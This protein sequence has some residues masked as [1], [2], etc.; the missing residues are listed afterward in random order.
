M[1]NTLPLLKNI[2]LVAALSMFA[3]TTLA[4]GTA[5]TYQGQLRSSGSPANGRY[6][7]TF[8]LF[9]AS[10]GGNPIG[11]TVNASGVVVS[12]GIFTVSLDFGA[13]FPGADR[14]LEISVRTNGAVSFNTLAPRQLLTPS[15]YSITAGTISG[16]LGSAA[17]SGNYTSPVNLNNPANSF[18]GNGGGLSN[19]NAS[20]LVSGTV[21]DNR[22]S[23]NVA[24]L[25]ASQVFTGSN[26]FRSSA[27]GGRLLVGDPMIG[28]I[29]TNRFTGMAFQYEPFFGE[30][31]LLSSYDDGFSSLGFY[32]KNNG[33][34]VTKRMVIDP[35]GNVGIGTF[36][37]LNLLSFGATAARTIG[38]D[39]N[40]VTGAANSLT[41]VGSGAQNG[42]AD[43]P[44]GD[45]IVAPGVGTGLGGGG[46]IRI[47]TAAAND[48]SGIADNTY[49]DRRIIVGKAKQ[50]TLSSP[51]FTSLFSVKLTGTHTAG[52]RVFYT[53]RA[54]DGASQ[55]ATEGG[56]IQWLATPNSITCTAETTDKIHLGTVNSGC[57]PGFFNPGS[58][59]GISIFDNV[60][61]S[62]PAPI[63]IHE[64]YFT[65]ENES[66][67]PIR[68]EP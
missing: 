66:G 41:I 65:I 47:Q 67:A 14:W 61:F 4:Q 6:D 30:G 51:G 17:L 7:F 36:S 2:A 11:S 68:L 15:P 64:V 1:K 22:L 38:M 25:N 34:P 5:F 8:A 48:I 44:G 62:S 23:P 3:A 18:T 56:V 43:Q 52:G 45:L 10:S 16:T 26:V 12:N 42:S 13:A 33:Q 57:T 37:P 40:S 29:D 60:A 59:P 54:T 35:N 53:V 24:L 39:R 63:V 31:A 19:L 50:L 27:A 21:A 28:A 46:N 32:T 20:A 58:Q 49:T 9:A 55:I